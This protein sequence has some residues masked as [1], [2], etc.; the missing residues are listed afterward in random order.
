MIF[1]PKT[2]SDETTGLIAALLK[3]IFPLIN[4]LGSA[5]FLIFRFVAGMSINIFAR[6]KLPSG[7]EI[8]KR[9]VAKGFLVIGLTAKITGIIK[10]ITSK[11]MVVFR[12]ID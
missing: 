3:D 11:M 2:S 7:S 9:E 8:G 4:L 1:W 6:V 10:I 12:E 5:P